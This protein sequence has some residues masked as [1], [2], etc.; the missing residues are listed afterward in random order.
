MI[1]KRDFLES[2]AHECHVAKHLFRQLPPGA[3]KYRPAKGQ[4]STLELLRYLSYC[5]VAMTEYVL[6]GKDEAYES[7]H[8]KS[9]TLPAKGFPA[10]MDR[11]ARRMKVL[12]SRIPEKQF[13]TRTVK[14]PWGIEGRLGSVMMNTS[15]KW[16]TAYRMQLFLYAKA[17]G[18]SKLSTA[19]CWLGKSPK[20][21]RRG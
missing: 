1:T 20:P 9:L 16:L 8:R 10:A 21:K 12:L 11:Q 7:W 5:A 15:L 19:D 6:S 17:A 3:L 13:E 2:V 4:R 18:A 14:L